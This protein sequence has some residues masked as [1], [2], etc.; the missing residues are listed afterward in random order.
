MFFLV[1]G[2]GALQ[3]SLLQWSV[4]HRGHHRFSDQEGDPYG[5][6]NGFWWAHVGWILRNRHGYEDPPLDNVKDL[7]DLPGVKFQHKFYD[8]I[9]LSVAFVV[10]AGLASLWGD[11]WGGFLV[12]GA[13]R[14]LLRVARYVVCEFGGPLVWQ[15]PLFQSRFGAQQRFDRIH[16]RGRGLP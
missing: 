4:D 15:P 11:F 13:L 1:F 12:T 3:T 7:A 6:R 8:P 5:V 10:P 14:A 2:A 9:G 16:Y